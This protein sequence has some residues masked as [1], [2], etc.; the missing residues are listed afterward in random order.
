MTLAELKDCILE[1]FCDHREGNNL[2]QFCVLTQA[3][4]VMGYREKFELLLGLLDG[5][6][7]EVLEGNSLKYEEAQTEYLNDFVA[8]E[9]KG[10]E[11]GH[12]AGTSSGK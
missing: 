4:L 11:Q 5:L 3:G 12:G 6:L 10:F 2:E 8:I 7:E 1:C 9:A